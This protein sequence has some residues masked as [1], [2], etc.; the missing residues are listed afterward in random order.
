MIEVTFHPAFIKQFK[1]KVK[2]K[3]E[4][5]DKFYEKLEI[6]ISNPF[7]S[8]LKTHKLSGKLSDLFSFSIE[9]DIRVVFNFEDSNHAIFLEFGKHDEVY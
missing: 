2:G 1:Q 9:Y 3:P 5:E 4:L 6:F 7:D 8:S